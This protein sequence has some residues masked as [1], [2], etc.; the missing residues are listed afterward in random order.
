MTRV[1]RNSPRGHHAAGRT[2]DIDPGHARQDEQPSAPD[3][4]DL[5]ADLLRW[6][7]SGAVWRVVH[8]TPEEVTVALLR[9]DG[10]EEMGRLR[11]G[12]STWL[13]FLEGREGSED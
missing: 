12:G 3:G 9:C 13:T 4:A 7:T 2:A 5:V 8:R 10:G 6:E 1:E 11:G